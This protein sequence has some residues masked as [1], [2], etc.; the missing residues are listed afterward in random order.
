MEKAG[1]AVHSRFKLGLSHYEARIC[2]RN[3]ARRASRGFDRDLLICH[4]QLALQHL[5]DV[6]VP[7]DLRVLG[8]DGKRVRCPQFLD[9]APG[10]SKF[11]GHVTLKNDGIAFGSL[12]L[13][14]EL[15]AIG[16]YQDVGLR[17]GRRAGRL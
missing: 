15:F 9:L 7:V 2:H 8:D 17:L 4:R 11:P 14:N 6:R 16:E 10:D 12:E 1:F 13:A 5:T 3:C